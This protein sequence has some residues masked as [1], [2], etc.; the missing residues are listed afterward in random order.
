M[1]RDRVLI[2]DDHAGFRA[3]ARRMLESEGWTVVGEAVDGTSAL[4]AAA[5]LRPDVVLL[6]I[7]LPDADGI[8]LAA[9]L[10]AASGRGLDVVLVS[11]R[12]RPAYGDR[13]ET[14]AAI[15]FIAKGDLRG[16]RLRALVATARR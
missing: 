11:T 4:L 3:T 10:A 12:D 1:T 16:D 9:R 5:A 2:V 13:L 7:G 6:D 15:G 8:D 14:S